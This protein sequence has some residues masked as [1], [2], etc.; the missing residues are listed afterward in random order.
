MARFLLI[1]ALLFSACVLHSHAQVVKTEVSQLV[2]RARAEQV[3]GD[4]QAAARDYQEAIRLQPHAIKWQI[5]LGLVQYESKEYAASAATL[6]PIALRHQDEFVS[7][8]FLGLDQLALHEPTRAIAFLEKAEALRP[9]DP[10]VPLALARAHARAKQYAQAVSTYRRALELNPLDGGVLF[11]TGMAY[12]DEVEEL[13][14]QL[15]E[16]SPPSSVFVR[17]LLGDAMMD[18]HRYNEAL[19]T[20]SEAEGE[21]SLVERECLASRKAFALFG[22]GDLSSAR[23]LW[24]SDSV[25]KQNCPLSHL[26]LIATAETDQETAAQMV[27]PSRPRDQAPTFSAMDVAWSVGILP[28]E[29]AA[30]L[31]KRLHSAGLAPIDTDAL[32]IGEIYPSKLPALVPAAVDVKQLASSSPKLALLKGCISIASAKE[33]SKPPLQAPQHV[34]ALVD[35]GRLADAAQCA[36]ALLRHTP[37][38]PELL[39]WSIRIN[40]RLASKALE[41]FRASDPHAPRTHL[42]LGDMDRQRG[43]LEAAE[44]EYLIV[45]A[46][47]PHNLVATIGLAIADLRDG[48]N[49]QSIERARAV[50]AEDPS[51]A[52]A[53]QVLGEALIAKHEFV[54]AEGPLRE[55]LSQRSDDAG[56]LHALLGRAEAGLG[57]TTTAIQ[58]LELGA[59]SDVDGSVHFQLSRVYRQTGN[60]EAARKAAATSA[61]LV[62]QRA[63]RGLLETADSTSSHVDGQP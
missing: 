45:L 2:S 1:L 18:Q 39:F 25:S 55:A 38:E 23:Q 5:N 60:Q 34:I 37:K 8:L 12:L 48:K 54:E 29:A 35:N 19:K 41:L 13:S 3:R 63:D 7:H 21:P 6:E 49:D 59:S 62:R 52:A 15:L 53:N 31:E 40:E 32:K 16:I 57:H 14:R 61:L 9:A 58:E 50:I 46:S 47:E 27:W 22:S 44:G 56:H 28:K 51:S 36:N 26:G 17:I 4:L 30:T 43:N 24:Q 20:Y 11:E 42:L 10:Q 33:S